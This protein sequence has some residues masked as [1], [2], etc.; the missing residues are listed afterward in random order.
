[1]SASSQWFPNAVWLPRSD[2]NEALRPPFA[3]EQT[4]LIP[5]MFQV[6]WALQD[7]AATST[8]STMA[9]PFIDPQ[10]PL[11]LC[12][13]LQHF[14]KKMRRVVRNLSAPTSTHPP[15]RCRTRTQKSLVKTLWFLPSFFLYSASP[16]EIV[17]CGS[18]LKH[19]QE[20]AEGSQPNA[21]DQNTKGCNSAALFVGFLAFFLFFFSSLFFFF[22]VKARQS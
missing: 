1:M 7:P 9:L 4:R 19:V 11:F 15:Q 10:R 6:P 20:A 16:M 18:S 21:G 13:F 3:W 12:S 17:S 5:V 22:K 14:L 2:L 8:R